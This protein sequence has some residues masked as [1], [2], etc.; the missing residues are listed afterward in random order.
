VQA[1]LGYTVPFAR[2]RQSAPE[3]FHQSQ[4]EGNLAH[5]ERNVKVKTMVRTAA[6]FAACIFCAAAALAQGSSAPNSATPA[7]KFAVINIRQAIVSTAEGK[8][9]SA[10]L[11]S[12]FAARQNELENLNKQINDLQQRLAAGDRTLNDEEKARL[13]Q[14]G[15]RMTTQLDRKKTEYQEDLNNAQGDAIDRIGRKMLDVINRY[16]RENGFVLVFN[17]ATE[18]SPVLYN[19]PQADITQDIIRLYDQAYP[20]KASATPA[21]KPKPP[22]QQKPQPR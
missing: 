7:P 8:Q 13:T 17:S 9:T 19:A 1:R 16:A 3:S 2:S 18:N 5:K 6:P 21:P 11:Q 14:Q 12:Q 15:Q 4:A 20:V 10:E 22:A